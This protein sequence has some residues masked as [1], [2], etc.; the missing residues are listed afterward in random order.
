MQN[1]LLENQELLLKIHYQQKHRNGK[2]LLKNQINSYLQT[3]EKNMLRL[4]RHVPLRQLFDT[5]SLQNALSIFNKFQSEKLIRN[6][7]QL[8]QNQNQMIQQ[9]YMQQ[10][11][12][13]QA[14]HLQI[15]QQYLQGQKEDKLQSI[16]DNKKVDKFII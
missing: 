6:Q 11:K 14:Q 9:Q 13:L 8:L 2:H 3:I 7:Q 10:K 1:L 16:Y 5:T 15:Q 4:A 12:H